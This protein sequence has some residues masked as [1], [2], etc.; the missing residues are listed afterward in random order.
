MVRKNAELIGE[1]ATI[2]LTKI[3]EQ[4]Q[5]ADSAEDLKDLAEAF[6]IVA[7]SDLEVNVRPKVNVT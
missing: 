4:A 1:T 2:L 6:G 5:R 3:K 7:A